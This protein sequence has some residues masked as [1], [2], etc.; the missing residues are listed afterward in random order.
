MH[1]SHVKCSIATC[2]YWLPYWTVQIT[3][4]FFHCI[5]FN[6][7]ALSKTSGFQGETKG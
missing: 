1:Q 2:G 5:M 6:W 7:T 3:E 4:H